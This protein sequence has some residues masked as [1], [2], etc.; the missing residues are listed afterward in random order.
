MSLDLPSGQKAILKP[1]DAYTADAMGDTALQEEGTALDKAICGL[2]ESIDGKAFPSFEDDRGKAIKAARNLLLNDYH[3][4]I[5]MAAASF[6]DGFFEG[7]VSD[8]KGGSFDAS[9]HLLDEEGNPQ[10]RFK[11]PPYP[12][13]AD[14][15]HEWEEEVPELAGKN[16]KFRLTLLDGSARARMLEDE[17]PNLNIDLVSR[18]PAYFDDE[19]QMWV[20]YDPKGRPPTWAAKILS[21]K[22]KEIDPVIQFSGIFKNRGRTIR[23]SM[24]AIPDFFL[25]DFT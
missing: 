13:G 2:V 22:A 5:F 7:K 20:L 3:L 21:R 15:K 8:G 10:E 4:I 9:L 24:F 16:V 14:K 11:P 18:N 17:M 25:R 1:Y 19:K 12:N 6:R 23:I